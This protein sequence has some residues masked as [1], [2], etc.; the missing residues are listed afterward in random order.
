MLELLLIVSVLIVDQVSK[1]LTELFI[2][3]GTSVP[4][5]EGVF[6]LSNVH[7]T[8]AAWGILAGKQWLFLVLTPVLCILLVLLLVK[9]RARIGTLG[10][11]CI[12]LLIAGACGNLIDR[13]VLSYVRD[14]FDF[15]LI[16]FPVFNVADCAITVG[17]ALLFL[18]T[19]FVKNG[20]IFSALEPEK[21]ETGSEAHADE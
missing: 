4:L 12:A 17:A 21:R 10:R 11:I 9:K 2:P 3:F 6:Q 16:H 14:M 7:N 18:D 19:L 13:A 15:C 20:S 1:Y 8:G 5:I